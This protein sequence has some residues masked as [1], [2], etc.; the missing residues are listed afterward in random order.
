MGG[1]GREVGHR[2]W[3]SGQLPVKEGDFKGKQKQRGA[4]GRLPV[5]V[6]TCPMAVVPI[7]FYRDKIVANGSRKGGKTKGWAMQRME[8]KGAGSFSLKEFD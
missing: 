8:A 1:G 4:C 5:E 7:E 3:G 2:R 6:F